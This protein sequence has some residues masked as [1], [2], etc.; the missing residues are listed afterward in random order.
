M[1][2][3]VP[4]AN[5]VI[6]SITSRRV[7]RRRVFQAS[8]NIRIVGVTRRRLKPSD[9]AHPWNIDHAVAAS[10]APNNITA[11]KPETTG[12]AIPAIAQKHIRSGS[13]DMSGLRTFNRHMPN[14]TTE[15]SALFT[16]LSEMARERSSPVRLLAMMLAAKAAGRKTTSPRPRPRSRIATSTALGNQ[17]AATLL[18]SRVS[19]TLHQAKTPNSR[20]TSTIAPTPGY[21]CALSCFN[22]ILRYCPS[23][24][25][26]AR[27]LMDLL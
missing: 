13:S 18:S 25:T 19:M 24:V 27:P 16:R 21:F 1:D 9:T 4:A 23:Y 12:A 5:V 7:G 8:A 15:I 14:Q 20:V 26:G 3:A 10:G 11:S 17:T 6:H 22:I 2:T